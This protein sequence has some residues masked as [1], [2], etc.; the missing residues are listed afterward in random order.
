LYNSPASPEGNLSGD[1]NPVCVAIIK[2]QEVNMNH[3]P[4][5]FEATRRYK[6]ALSTVWA[7]WC[8]AEQLAKWWGPKECS[9]A[10]LKLEFRE[11]GFFHYAMIAA[12]GPTSWG[13]FNYREI[14]PKKK[15]VWLNSF[16]NEMGGI[17]RAPFSEYCP[18]EIYNCVSLSE[19]T[20]GT[21]IHLQAYPFG[22]SAEE[23]AFFSELC[24]TGSLAMGFGGTFDRLE[25][26][27]NGL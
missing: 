7:A 9:L 1:S 6:H 16:A 21:M 11:G 25:A 27:L 26:L 17:A 5:V 22:A 20:E 14:V 4:V 3:N 12:A 24:D 18:L 15:L 2:N 10:V 13:R 23:I 19:D 8:D